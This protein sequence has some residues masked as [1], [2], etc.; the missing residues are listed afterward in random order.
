[1][2]RGRWQSKIVVVG[3]LGYPPY[4]L[5]KRRVRLP[6]NVVIYMA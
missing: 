1:M 3:E 4:V 5:C 6:H 2:M